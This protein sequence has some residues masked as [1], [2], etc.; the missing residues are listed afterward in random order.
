MAKT[1]IIAGR[2][3]DKNNKLTQYLSG[4]RIVYVKGNFSPVL[5]TFANINNNK[6]KIW[7][8]S[9][10]MACQRCRRLGHHTSETDKCDAYIEDPEIITIRSHSMYYAII[11]LHP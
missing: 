7:H 2:L 9:Q 10:Q 8:Q 3:R 1:G 11:T 6:C 5:H 4:D